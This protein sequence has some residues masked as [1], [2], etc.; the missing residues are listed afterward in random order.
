MSYRPPAMRRSTTSRPS[1]TKSPRARIRSGSVTDRYA[2]T[3][4]SSRPMMCTLDITPVDYMGRRWHRRPMTTYDYLDGEETNR[5]RELAYGVLREPP[6]PFFSHQEV[7]FRVA[8][9]LQNHVE[10][11]SLGRIG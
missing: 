3:R 5:Q 8:L 11:R 6:A 2:S 4:G 10:P 1:A 7:V 9:L